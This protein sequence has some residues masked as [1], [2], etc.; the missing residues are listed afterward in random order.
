MV[1]RWTDDFMDAMRDIGDP[2]ADA[3]IEELVKHNSIDEVNHLMHVM[4]MNHDL[5]AEELPDIIEDYLQE[6][7]KLPEW[8]DRD[9]M[10][11]GSRLFYRYGPEIVQMLFGASL[12]ILYATYPGA[13]VLMATKRM[14]HDVR[15]R[16]IETGQFVI[17]VM[18]DNAWD[19]DGKG[20]RTTQKV[21]LMHATIRYYLYKHPK[22]SEQWRDEW[23]VPICQE[24]L[25]GTMLSFSVTIM[26]SLEK[27]N[28]GLS[29]EEKE[30]FLHLWKVIGHVLGVRDDLM[31]DDFADA[32]Y[33]MT[34]YMHRNH[35][36]TE[37]G[38]ILMKAMV[39]FWYE[40]VPGRIF[41]GVTSGWS[42]LWVGE[43]IADMLG[44]PP[45][46]WT[47]NLL[48]ITRF[49]WGIEDRLEDRIVPL[50]WF[51]RFWTRKLMK[52]LLKQQRGGKRPDFSIPDTLQESWGMK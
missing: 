46:D 37:T 14:T 26:H 7:A 21:R 8:A 5:P 13:E 47:Y 16:I 40:S 15:R 2:P 3:V 34:R 52:A 22:W 49:V 18:D 24:D 10:Q 19:D 51:T 35:R 50:R 25:A 6:T 44:I 30:A 39:D 32:E 23:K 1:E 12:P 33:M 36:E 27:S 42:R 43:Q 28:V 11:Q 9:L 31:P 4:V 41:D 29:I 38:R 17:D 48:Q 20:I 45:Y